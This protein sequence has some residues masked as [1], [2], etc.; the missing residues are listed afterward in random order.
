[1]SFDVAAVNYYFDPTAGGYV[2]GL[3]G[4]AALDAVSSDGSSG[5]NDPTGPVFGI[6]GGYDFWVADEWGIGPN[7]R[8]MYAPTTY[9]DGGITAKYNVLSIQIGAGATFH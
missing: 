8:L 4:F 5:G 3:L 9:S 1:M 2:Q 7:L 6:G